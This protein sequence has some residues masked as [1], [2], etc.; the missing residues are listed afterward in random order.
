M[1]EGIVDKERA[2]L[3]EYFAPSAGAP[4]PSPPAQAPPE[5]EARARLE[6]LFKKKKP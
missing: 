1:A 3:C 6:A 2:N 5:R 4:T